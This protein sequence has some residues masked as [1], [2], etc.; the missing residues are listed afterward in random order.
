[1]SIANKLY[2]VTNRGHVTL[3][4]AHGQSEALRHIALKDISIEL[5][6]AVDVPMMLAAGATVETV[7]AKLAIIP[8]EP[9]KQ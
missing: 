9:A 8:A 3:V 4:A 5:A 6:R 7:S 2:K 1:M